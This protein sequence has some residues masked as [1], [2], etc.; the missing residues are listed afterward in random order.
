MLVCMTETTEQVFGQVFKAGRREGAENSRCVLL[1][2]V[3][4]VEGQLLVLGIFRDI[5]E[6]GFCFR[7]ILKRNGEIF[8]MVLCVSGLISLDC[9]LF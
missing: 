5:N 3:L 4:V 9:I 7:E 2:K 6:V 1:S 8:T